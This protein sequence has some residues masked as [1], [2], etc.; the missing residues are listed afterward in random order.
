MYTTE[1]FYQHWV[2]SRRRF[3]TLL[4]VITEG[5]YNDFV[6]LLSKKVGNSS[7]SVGFIIRHIADVEL[8]HSKNA[9][10]QKDIDIV[11]L[12]MIE[13]YDLSEWTNWTELMEYQNYAYNCLDQGIL[14]QTDYD[15]G[16][17]LNN[18]VFG[19]KTKA[20]V[21]GSVISHTS[22]HAGQL[23]MILE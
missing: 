14:I 20:E 21:L 9:F 5:Y 12:T 4:D 22:Y 7:R 15:W 11:G 17:R 6:S 13:Q 16:I 19:S 23:S 2:E 1:L 18:K 10:G 8:L 3:T